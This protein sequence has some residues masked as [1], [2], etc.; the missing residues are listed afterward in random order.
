MSILQALL[1][2]RS[3]VKRR[4]FGHEIS[5]HILS[6]CSVLGISVVLLDDWRA[7]WS[8]RTTIAYEGGTAVY[9]KYTPQII[10]AS[11]ERL[12]LGHST[13]RIFV[14][15]AFD[16]LPICDIREVSWRE[17]YAAYCFVFDRNGVLGTEETPVMMER[18]QLP[19]FREMDKGQVSLE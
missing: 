12:D 6:G 16:C 15:K 19:C 1:A 17:K 8:Q 14:R 3:G 9:M 5:R 2:K 7:C 4:I 13:D 10:P 18:Q 11:N